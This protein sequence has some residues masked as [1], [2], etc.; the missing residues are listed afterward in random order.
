MA[1]AKRPKP[2][3]ADLT[4]KE[5]RDRAMDLLAGA[6]VHAE[7]I[8]SAAEKLGLTPDLLD[9]VGDYL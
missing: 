4:A 1:E 3:P 5:L 8:G 7:R 6:A 2:R 9:G